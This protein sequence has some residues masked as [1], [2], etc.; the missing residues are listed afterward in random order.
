MAD[1]PV[2]NNRNPRYAR[3]RNGDGE[4][5][6]HS[7]PPPGFGLNQTDLMDIAN[8]VATTL[9]GLIP[10]FNQPQPPPLVQN[11]TKYHY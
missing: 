5:D 2:R 10:N 7:P 4:L 6:E 3:N 1:R 9:Q 11:G 8:I